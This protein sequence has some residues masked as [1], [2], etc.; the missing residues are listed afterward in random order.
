MSIEDL[1]KEIKKLVLK[2]DLPDIWRVEVSLPPELEEIPITKEIFITE[3]IYMSQKQAM[4]AAEDLLHNRIVP[5][6]TSHNVITSKVNFKPEKGY[7]H[8]MTIHMNR[9]MAINSTDCR[10]S[11]TVN[12][13]V[14]KVNQ[15]QR[16]QEILSAMSHDVFNPHQVTTKEFQKIKKILVGK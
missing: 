13:R 15:S 5:N 14:A 11:I 8:T 3:T 12:I 7:T 16:Q 9:E 2:S 1:A 4:L 6:P 10:T